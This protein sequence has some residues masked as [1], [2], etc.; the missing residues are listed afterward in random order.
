MTD[1]TRVRAEMQERFEYLASQSTPPRVITRYDA[2]Y[3]AEALRRLSALEGER[4]GWKTID[5]APRDG[6][7]I[8]IA[9]GQDHVSVG[10]YHRNDDDLHPWK[11]MDSQ[12]EG[13]PI[14]NGARDDQYGPS[15][16]R[17]LPSAPDGEGK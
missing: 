4:E 8:L 3:V 12:G 7:H 2:A 10:S 14:L 11:F 17:P 5:S 9:F 6:T 15:K 13:L 1:E 16:W